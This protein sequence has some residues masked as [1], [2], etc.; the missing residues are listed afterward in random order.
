MCASKHSGVH[1]HMPTSI[2]RKFYCSSS[3]R[4]EDER[5]K[6]PKTLFFGL[7]GAITLLQVE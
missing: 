7:S 2:H 6:S 3:H 5:D 1:V 4:L